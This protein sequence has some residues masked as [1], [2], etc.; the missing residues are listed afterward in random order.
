[1]PYFAHFPRSAETDP[2]VQKNPTNCLLEVANRSRPG[3]DI[4]WVAFVGLV[5]SGLV[6]LNRFEMQGKFL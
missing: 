4:A 5:L 6:I 1:M 3:Q 2:Y